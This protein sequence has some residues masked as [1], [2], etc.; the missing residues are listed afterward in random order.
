MHDQTAAIRTATAAVRTANDPDH[1][2]HDD[3]ELALR[4]AGAIRAGEFPVCFDPTPVGGVR[5]DVSE[6]G[7]TCGAHVVVD[8]AGGWQRIDD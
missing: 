8:A 1:P 3:L 4:R 6:D 2:A 5:I 7:E